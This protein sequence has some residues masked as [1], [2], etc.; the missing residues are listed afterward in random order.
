MNYCSVIFH[1]VLKAP[2]PDQDDRST[3]TQNLDI[4]SAS[5]LNTANFPA[6]PQQNTEASPA[7]TNA[8]LA[9][10]STLGPLIARFVAAGSISEP[11][12]TVTL[13]RDSIEIGGNVGALNMGQLPANVQNGSLT[14][15]PLRRYTANQGGLRPPPDSPNEVRWSIFGN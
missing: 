4:E 2:P 11:L 1:R 5:N 6:F 10:F 7:V 9:S 15:V 12:F 8:V 3:D 14:W 13:Q